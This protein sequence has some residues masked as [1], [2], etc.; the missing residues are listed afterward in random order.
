MSIVKKTFYLALSLIG[1]IFLSLVVLFLSQRSDIKVIKITDCLSD[2]KVTVY[3]E[4]SKPEDIV[5]LPDNRHLLISEF[6]AIVPLSPENLTGQI[7]LFDTESL[8]KKEI[9]ITLGENDWGQLSCKR[10]DI[11]FSPHGVDLNQR[12]DG[13]YQLA[14][15]NHMPMETIEMFELLNI[16]NTWSLI[17]RGCVVAPELGYFNDVAL[18]N[19]GSFFTTQMYERGLSYLSL[20]YI[21]YT[22]PDTGFVYQWEEESGFI[23]VPNSEGS[24][25]NGISISDD[26]KHL[27]INYVFNHRT[28]KLNLENLTI[29]AE[30]FSKGSP[31]NSSIDGDFIWVA[32]QDNTGTDLL[33]HCNEKVL[34]CSLPFTIFK[35]RQSDLSE[36]A[37]FSFSQTQIGSV[38]VAVPHKNKVWLGTFLGDRMASFYNEN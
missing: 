25:P 16:H 7:S 23:K 8:Q 29:E 13:R 38:T 6:G 18:R 28:S 32:T 9:A 27:F 24:F 14:V 19:D 34:Q 17:W 4:F 26:E 20:I 35:L 22:K 10:D 36:V 33:I 37:S 31:D 30:H 2:S 21:S 11:V 1:V 5:V 15:V 3:C 12:S